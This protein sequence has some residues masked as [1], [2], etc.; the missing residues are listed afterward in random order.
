MLVI[1]SAVFLYYTIWTLLLVSTALRTTNGPIQQQRSTRDMRPQIPKLTPSSQT[2]LRRRLSP[3]PISL[4]TARLGYSRTGHSPPRRWRCCWK[5]PG[6]GHDPQPAEEGIE[7][8]AKGCGG[9][10]KVRDSLRGV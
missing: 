6:L 10:V 7:G 2:A 1:A 3:T 5:L 4:P 8:Q 9:E